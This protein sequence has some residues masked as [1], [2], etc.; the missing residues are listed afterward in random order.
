MVSLD[1]DFMKIIRPREYKNLVRLGNNND[2]GYIVPIDV[3]RKCR[4]LVS[5]GYGNDFSF[6]R[7]ISEILNDFNIVIY[8]DA[9]S[10]YKLTKN[11]FISI[12]NRIFLGNSEF[13]PR[14]KLIDLKTFIQMKITPK[15][16]YINRRIVALEPMCR[17]ETSII[18]TLPAFENYAMKMDIEGSE[19]SCLK[20]LATC[21]NAPLVLLVEFHDITL[22]LEDF[23]SVL[24][25]LRID[26]HLINTHINNF[27]EII[28]G[29][30]QVIEMS[31][32]N[33]KCGPIPDAFV[34]SIPSKIDQPNSIRFAEIIYQY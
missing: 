20:V 5:Y 9:A 7:N 31:F 17:I 26:F 13:H 4:Q 2:G 8:D 16:Q 14:R 11:L 19:Y 22:N 10:F 33:K 34:E 23:I 30:P 28:D 1:A 21:S 32:V 15:I 29:I 6:E 18:K 27:G 25:L 24:E 3:M 12:I